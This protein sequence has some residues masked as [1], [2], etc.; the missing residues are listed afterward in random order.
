MI[1]KIIAFIAVCLGSVLSFVTFSAYT[2]EPLD[3]EAKELLLNLFWFGI[4]VATAGGSYLVVTLK[5]ISKNARSAWTWVF[6]I[7]LAFV[8][9]YIFKLLFKYL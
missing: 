5:N 6:L 8:I 2:F 3:D 7:S 9:F 4:S 1:S